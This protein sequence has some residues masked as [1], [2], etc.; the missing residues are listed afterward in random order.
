M[1]FSERLKIARKEAKLSQ[2]ELADEIS[3]FVD[4]KKITRTAIAQWE[5]DVVSNIEASNLL[6]VCKVLNV[7]PEWLWYGIGEKYSEPNFLNELP[8]G[9]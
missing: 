7:R 4:R 1:K 3:R 5:N 2:Q 8:K 6:K 9:F